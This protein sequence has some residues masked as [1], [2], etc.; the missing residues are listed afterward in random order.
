MVS[1]EQRA[2]NLHMDVEAENLFHLTS[3]PPAT[4][5]AAAGPVFAVQIGNYATP[6]T[7]MCSVYV[8]RGLPYKFINSTSWTIDLLRVRFLHFS[9]SL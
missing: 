6:I 8:P 9:T 2:R 1:E 7:Q 3:P 4:P 5:E